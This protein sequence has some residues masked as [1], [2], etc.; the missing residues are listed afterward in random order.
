MAE[1]RARLA[2][3][4]L[5]ALKLAEAELVGREWCDPRVQAVLGRLRR[6][7]AAMQLLAVLCAQDDGGK[8][9]RVD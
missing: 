6:L 1:T 7:K 9:G 2:A 5:S 4:A 3:L 8:D